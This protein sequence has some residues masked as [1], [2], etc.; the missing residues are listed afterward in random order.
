MSIN[1]EDFIPLCCDFTEELRFPIN[2]LNIKVNGIWKNFKDFE[3]NLKTTGGINLI[4]S[5]Q[6][7]LLDTGNP[8]EYCIL[9]DGYLCDFKKK[10]GN[11]N[12]IKERLTSFYDIIREVY[13]STEIFEFKFNNTVFNSKIGFMT[14][15]S[16][17]LAFSINFG[18][19][20]I[21]QILNIIF[22]YDSEFYYY[23]TNI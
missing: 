17:T 16:A 2:D 9:S 1:L 3:G 8:K 12:L 19:N 10:F 7:F 5:L 20:S 21:K 11:I 14:N 13:I 23:C 22:P 4:I 15:I 18:L 6:D